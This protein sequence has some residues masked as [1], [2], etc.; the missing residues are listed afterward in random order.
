M[1]YIPVGQQNV[2][3]GT[4]DWVDVTH[5]NANGAAKFTDYLINQLAESTGVVSKPLWPNR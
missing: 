1:A 3:I 4:D 5:L 2:E